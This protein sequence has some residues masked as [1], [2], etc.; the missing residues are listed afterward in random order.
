[1]L[2]HRVALLILAALVAGAGCGSGTDTA[3]SPTPTSPTASPSATE[4][5]T[6]TGSPTATPEPTTTGTPTTGP[7]PTATGT[8]TSPTPSATSAPVLPQALL[9]T[10]VTVIPTT[11]RV[12]ALTFDAGASDAGVPSILQTLAA[13]RVAATFFVTGDF[14]RRYPDAVRAMARAGHLVGNHSD[15]HPDFSTLTAAQLA[16]QL[17]NAQAVIG[18][19]IGG[20]TQP[21]FRFPFGAADAASIAGVNTGG[22]AGIGWT[23]DTLGWKGTSGGQSVDSVVSRV[24]AALRPGA[25][26]LM[27]VG[28]NPDDGSTLDAA[29]LPT[30]I[31][32]L[33]QRGYGFVTLTAALP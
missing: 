7:T 28:A 15:T 25:I 32:E 21:W 13:Q 26:V 9:G 24:V 10:V 6:S 17:T 4:E 29:A 22:Y 18:P 1:V 3:P 14:A 19:L 11:A 33:R 20:P 31:A 27:H 23:V 5:P 8:P 2:R 16:A 12:V 30:I